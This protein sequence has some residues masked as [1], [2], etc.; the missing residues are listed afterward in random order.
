MG[1]RCLL[2]Y[3]LECSPVGVST[4]RAHGDSAETHASKGSSLSGATVCD[5]V[6]S[7]VAAVLTQCRVSEE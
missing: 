2:R 4:R 5:C 3:S 1:K 7:C 6:P